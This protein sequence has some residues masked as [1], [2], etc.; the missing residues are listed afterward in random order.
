MAQKS[1]VHVQFYTE[2]MP[3]GAASRDAGRQVFTEVEMCKVLTL[4]DKDNNLVIR[5]HEPFMVDR[6]NGGHMTPAQRWPEEYRAF[7]AGLADA[8]SGT[9]L[10][11]L[12]FLSKAQVAEFR[13]AN[14]KTAEQLAS[15][16]E[17]AVAKGFGWRDLR[18]KAAIWLDESDKFAVAAKAQEERDAANARADE[19]ARRLA[20]MEAKLAAMDE[21]KRGPGRPRKDAEAA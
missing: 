6:E 17:A 18:E 16:S 11:H 1:S 3:D 12:P 4:G 9:P 10:S 20:E 14:I 2:A 5:A 13:V 19:M 8:V 7:K 15:L 21:P